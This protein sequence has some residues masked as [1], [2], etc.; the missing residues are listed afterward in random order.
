MKRFLVFALVILSFITTAQTIQTPDQFLG[1]EL[2][3]RF[4]RHHRVVE[5]FKYIDNLSANVTVTQYG[6]TNELRPLI[7]AVI[8]SPENFASLEQIRQ[9][10]L[11]RAGV[12]EGS[13]TSKVAIVWLSY[14]VHG[15]EASSLE[16]SMKTLYELVNP[17]NAKTKEWLKNTVVIMDPCIN[18]D[19]RDRYANFFNQYGNNPYNSSGD[20]KEHREPWPGGR[21]N[22]YLFDLNRDWAWLTQKES[23]ARIKIYNEWLPHVHV[24]F[25]EQGYNN[26]YYFAPAVEPFHEVIS[27]WQREFQTMIG[28]NHAK[29]FDEQGWLYFTK[30]VFDLYYP[31]YGDTYPTYSGAIGMTYEQGGGGFGGLSITTRE[32]DPL[33][34]KDRLTH[35]HT[36]GLSTV[37]ITSL[38]AT[39][40]VDEFEKYSK[41]NLNNPASPYKTFV[42]KGDNNADKVNKLTKWLDSHSIKYGHPAAGKVTRGFDYQTQTTGTANVSTDDVII[43]IYQPKSRFITTLFEPVSKLPDSATYDIT[44]WNVMYNYDLKG[45]ALNERINVGKAYQPKAVDNANTLAKPYAYIFK[46]ESLRDVEFLAELLN[47]NIKV[48]AAEKAFSVAGQNFEP[49]T[50]VVTRRNNEAIADFDNLIKKLAADKERKIYTSTT[51]FVDRGKDFGSSSVTYLKAPKIAVLFGEQ[52]SSLSAGEIW[53]FFEEQLHYPI[54]Q[55]GTEYFNSIDL[56]KYDVLVVPEGRYRVFDESTLD[57]VSN[58]VSGGG[59]LIVIANALTSFAEKK[60]FALKAYA[61]DAEKSEAEKKEKEARQNEALGRYEDAQRKQLSDAI[62][63]AIYKVT[64]DKSHPLAFGMRESYYTLKTNE[65]RYGYLQNGWNV[66]VINGNAK[67]V[68][69][70]AGYRINKKMSNSLILGVEP[71]GQGNI[72]YMVD[73]P[74][75]RNFWESSKMIFSN[76]VFMVQ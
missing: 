54:T 22:H 49:G 76:A 42:I 8:A 31:S 73:N 69:G 46:Y 19:G 47:K 23:R 10:N 62:S 2:G 68:Q 66:G 20:A 5:Y 28:K 33:T 26:P 50:L 11:K 75:F 65:L 64:L 6:E 52:T 29:Y 13:P 43:N 72:I 32:G 67:P 3:S 18:P 4:T 21:A 51:G 35:H 45:Y 9:D 7:Y 60:G 44:A 70:F 15:N 59:R 37:E 30:E 17:A 24:D 36:S 34:L 27:P 63:G 16:A 58:W 57:R 61:N 48:R 55:I 1:Y 39:R 38:N 56:T 53:H 40:V 14:N 74:L 41:E 25:H 12:L 71:K